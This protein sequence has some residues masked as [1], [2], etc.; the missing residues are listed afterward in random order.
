MNAP[1]GEF[2]SILRG[3]ERAICIPQ[4]LVPERGL[5]AFLISLTH[6]MFLVWIFA[7]RLFC[8]A[9]HRI[10]DNAREYSLI[11]RP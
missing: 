11:T 3:P 9:R 6:G 10:S 2:W 5:S 8:D 7:C 1:S 4:K